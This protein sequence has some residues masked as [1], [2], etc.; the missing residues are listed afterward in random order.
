IKS[1]RFRLLIAALAVV[2]GSAIAKSQ[3]AADAPPPPPMHGHFGMEG[4]GMGFFA[5]SLNLTDEQQAQ[6]KTIMENAH[7]SM[8]PLRQQSQQ[9][10][11][12]FLRTGRGPNGEKRV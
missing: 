1:F 10:K 2:L 3:T 6:M 9:M 12:K 11:N 7:T 5:K 8:K 4:R